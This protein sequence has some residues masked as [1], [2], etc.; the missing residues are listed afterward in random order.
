MF[1]VHMGLVRTG[2]LDKFSI[3]YF[4]ML[5]PLIISQLYAISTVLR[6]DYKLLR[7][8]SSRQVDEGMAVAL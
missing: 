7:A 8:E 5:V 2:L 4:M 3:V 1:F 6:L